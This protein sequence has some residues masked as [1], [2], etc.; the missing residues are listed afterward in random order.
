MVEYGHLELIN[1]EGKC[2]EKNGN[3]CL[4]THLLGEDIPRLDALRQFRDEVL[5]ENTNW[6]GNHKTILRIE[7]SN[8]WGNERG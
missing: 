3:N 8:S 2:W 1:A 6:S 5:A 7:S 4:I